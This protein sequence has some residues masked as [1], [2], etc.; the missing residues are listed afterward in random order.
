VISSKSSREL[1]P[2]ESDASSYLAKQ[3]LSDAV[4]LIAAI[5]VVGAR[6]TAVVDSDF[7]FQ[8]PRG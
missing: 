6:R 8:T 1:V 5:V 4:M 2:G 7:W 3:T